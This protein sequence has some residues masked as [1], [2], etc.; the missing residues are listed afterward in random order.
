MRLERLGFE[1]GVKLA[2]EI[3]GVVADFA[4]FDIHAVGSLAG[5]A[6]AVLLQNV[7]VFAIEFVAVTVALADFLFAVGGAGEA[8]FLEQAG[9]RA[10]AHGTA[11]LIHAF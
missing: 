2:A 9:V 5:E 10:E 11:E 8:A 4:D 3:P 7:L 6:Q 1:L